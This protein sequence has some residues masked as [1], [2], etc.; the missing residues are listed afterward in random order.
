MATSK[1]EKDRQGKRI[2]AAVLAVG[3]ALLLSAMVFGHKAKPDQDG[4]LGA[5]TSSTVIVLDQSEQ[6]SV[7]TRNE[8]AAR[9]MA[10]VASA[11]EVGER[12]TV[13]DVSQRSKTALE[14]VFSRCK[15]ANSGN[16]LY[17][18]A[19][20]IAKAYDKDFIEP[21]RKVLTDIHPDD[22]ESPVAQALVDVS[23][24]Q[25]LRAPKNSLL[26]FSDML[27]H[28]PN[29]FSLYACTD[30]KAGIAAFRASRRGAQERP[31]FQNT[32]IKVNLIPRGNLSPQVLACRA[33]MWSWFFGDNQGPASAV[34]FDYLP[35]SVK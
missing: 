5:P 30:P 15:P 27:E 25:Y 22:V 4:C 8:I 32:D 29:K 26:V 13:F 17:E 35:G 3:G 34:A 9:V 20:H 7:Q 2:V 18:D 19:R 24:S 21:L 31:T 12:V 16:R 33:L 6:V 11:A 28:V 14:P 23:L 1:A 10:H